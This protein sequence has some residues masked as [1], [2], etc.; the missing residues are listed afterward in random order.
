MI[1]Q[2]SCTLCSQVSQLVYKDTVGRENTPGKD[3]FSAAGSEDS[4]AVM[5]VGVS[6]D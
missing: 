6:V 2:I 1:E 5:E 4:D 3:S